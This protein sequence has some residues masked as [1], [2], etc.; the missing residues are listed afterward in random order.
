M[1]TSIHTH[2]IHFNL[3]VA[4]R[5]IHSRGGSENFGITLYLWENAT[6]HSHCIEF[7]FGR[8]A[9]LWH[10]LDFLQILIKKK[11]KTKITKQYFYW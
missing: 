2:S 1:E 4:A 3:L 6:L 8:K 10:E 11:K 5:S 9:I 7:D